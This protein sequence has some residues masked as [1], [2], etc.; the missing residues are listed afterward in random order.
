MN[1]VG[2]IEPFDP[3][4]PSSFSPWVARFTLFC[5]AN[6]VLPEPTT[7]DGRYFAQ[8][9]RRRNLFLTKIGA[10]AFSIIYTALL[11]AAPETQPI[12]YLVQ[13]LKSHFE[14]DGL[15]EANRFTFHQRV[16][17]SNESV[18]E[19]IAALQALAVNCNWGD[20]YDEALKTRLICGIKHND[21]RQKLVSTPNLTFAAAK[22]MALTDDSLRVQMRA[23]A[24][25]NAQA[26]VQEGPQ[27]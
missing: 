21:T 16:Q 11:P 10:R 19:F 27:W 23:L 7:A 25:A 17:H 9:N 8:S 1:T 15:V 6:G 2:D 12:P 5:N 22:T 4:G 13:E 24:Q 26:S 20:F 14:P 3:N 18:F